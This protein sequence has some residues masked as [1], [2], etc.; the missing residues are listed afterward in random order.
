MEYLDK[1][2]KLVREK[3]NQ[4]NLLRLRCAL[5]ETYTTAEAEKILS[6]YQ[7]PDGSWDYNTAEEEP[8]RIGSLGGTIHLPIHHT[9]GFKKRQ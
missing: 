2:I 6:S 5:H 1:A 4:L 8:D 3:G 7:F 9:G